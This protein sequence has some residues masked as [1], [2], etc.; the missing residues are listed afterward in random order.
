MKI[1]LVMPMAGAGARFKKDGYTV[2]KPLIML[3]GK[4]FFWHSAQS[5]LKCFEPESISF[6]ILKEHADE[7]GLDRE[8]LSYFPD[9]R[10]VILEKMLNGAVLSCLAGVTGSPE[11]GVL[12]GEH[13]E[14]GMQ[15]PGS[16]EPDHAVL[17]NDCDHS[18]ECEALKR[19]AE[20]GNSVITP[21]SA[22]D[23]A[24]GVTPDKTWDG[25]LL[26][27][28]SDLPKFSYVEADENGLA[29]RTREK[30]VISSH[31]VCGAYFFRSRGIFE[32]YAAR[33]LKTCGYSEYFMSGVY[34]EM[35]KDGR[36]IGILPTDSH[37][38]FG[39][40]AEY[41]ELTGSKA[42]LFI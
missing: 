23:A 32:E 40:P 30:E 36:R 29:V 2:P 22:A 14:S 7:F 9:A 24:A 12:Q 35:I 11:Y 26:T 18:F 3:D 34:N 42:K 28:E 15:H 27:F 10:V 41:E 17:F 5:V 19:F 1:D 21:E 16:L 6:V 13:E 38:S 25:A 39:T 20:D 31:A 37:T 4:P 8:I 33:Y